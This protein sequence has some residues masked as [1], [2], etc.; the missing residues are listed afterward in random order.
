MPTRLIPLA[1]AA[2]VLAEH[3][4]TTRKRMRRGELRGTKKGDGPRA[5]WFVTDRV[6]QAY[7]DRRTRG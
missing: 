4:E 3:P 2:A 5:R 6:L 1:E 7:I